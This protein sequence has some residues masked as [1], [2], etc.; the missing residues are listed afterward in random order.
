M[1]TGEDQIL[2]DAISKHGMLG[3]VGVDQS[4]LLSLIRY[5]KHIGYNAGWEDAQFKFNPPQPTLSWKRHP[6]YGDLF[7]EEEFL[8]RVKYYAITP[9]D[10]SGEW[11]TENEVSGVDC[12]DCKPEGATHVMWYNK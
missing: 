3:L 12:W 8:D 10:G 4:I 11:A 5:A 7:T 6:K 2:Q 9:D 1:E